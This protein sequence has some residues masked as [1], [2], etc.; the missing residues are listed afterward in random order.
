MKC[1]MLLAL[2]SGQRMQTLSAIKIDN[3]LYLDDKVIFN[4][5]KILKTTRPGF[6]TTVEIHSYPSEEGLRTVRCLSS[7]VRRTTEVRNTDYVFLALLKPHKVVC[8]QTVSRWVSTFIRN[9]GISDNFCAH[10]TRSA[11]FSKANAI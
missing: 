8:S 5:D 10:S 11:A 4:F 7:Y 3:I 9:S 6:H 2:T 1:A